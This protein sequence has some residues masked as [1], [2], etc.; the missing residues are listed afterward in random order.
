MHRLIQ[1]LKTTLLGGVLILLPAWVATL[2]LLKALSQLGTLVDPVSQQLPKE[3]NHPRIMALLL[4]I[5]V[6]FLIGLLLRTLIGR[7][8]AQSVEAKVLRKL[9]GYSTLSSVAKQLGESHEN[10]GFK[11]ALVDMENA[12]APCFIVEVHADTRVT[13]FVPSSPTPA[14]GIILI[15]D[16]ARVHPVD[17]SVAKMF[18]CVSKW[19]A[20]S[21]ELLAASHIP[22]A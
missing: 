20:G 21:N 8:I 6:C 18:A 9:P 13:V 10:R 4:L 16:A 14:A 3:V 7:Q 12:L 1:F 19:G 22:P 5:L 2:L 15:I 17:V 11:P